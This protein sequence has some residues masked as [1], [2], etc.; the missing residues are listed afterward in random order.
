MDAVETSTFEKYRAS[1][2][3]IEE[4]IK[5]F[6]EASLIL[7]VSDADTDKIIKEAVSAVSVLFE[8]ID[9]RLKVV[10]KVIT[11]D[12]KFVKTSENYTNLSE[13]SVEIF[14]MLLNAVLDSIP[15]IG[16]YY[17]A[18]SAI[19]LEVIEMKVINIIRH[20]LSTSC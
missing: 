2:C 4:T 17:N 20:I 1:G 6:R 5:T 12:S 18:E 11:S 8:D 15:I 7:G 10:N 13:N 14:G 3:K 16:Q 19:Q 9:I